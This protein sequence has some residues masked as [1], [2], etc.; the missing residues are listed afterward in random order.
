MSSYS[1][2]ESGSS[3]GYDDE[4][5][6][7]T[8]ESGSEPV[9][10][11]AA[12]GCDMEKVD[13]PSVEET[14]TVGVALSGGGIRSASFCLGGLQ[15][16]ARA[17]VLQQA[18]YLSSVSGGGYTASAM[19]AMAKVEGKAFD[20]GAVE[21]V[22]K[23]HRKMVSRS[24]WLTPWATEPEN[25]G[26]SAGWRF[27]VLIK[28]AML[29]LTCVV[30]LFTN[31]VWGIALAAP[32]T[33]IIDEFVGAKLRASS[34]STSFFN[35]LLDLEVPLAFSIC[36]GC[37]V[38]TIVTW[39][40]R[41]SLSEKPQSRT[42]DIL[43]TGTE[44]TTRL[45]ALLSMAVILL[46][47][48]LTILWHD[49]FNS[50]LQRTAWTLLVVFILISVT[51]AQGTLRRV[52]LAVGGAIVMAAALFGTA[53]IAK[54]CIEDANDQ[55]TFA[56]VGD[57]SVWRKAY[58]LGSFALLAVFPFFY[59]PV[60]SLLPH[61]YEKLLRRAFFEDPQLNMGHV[62][63]LESELGWPIWLVGTTQTDF[64]AH[65]GERYAAS[66][67]L[68]SSAKSGSART[69][70]RKT[71][72]TL[73]ASRAVSISGAVISF[74]MGSKDVSLSP[75]RFLF[76]SLNLGLGWYF[77]FSD[78]AEL[79]ALV[80]NGTVAVLGA[81]LFLTLL[82][83][84]LVWIAVGSV[85]LLYIA[86]FFPF[87]ERS[88]LFSA[89]P[90]FRTVRVMLGLEFYVQPP[91]YMYLSDGGH[92]E[93]LGLLPLFQRKVT[94]IY[95]FDGGADPTVGCT[96]LLRAMELAHTS[97]DGFYVSIVPSEAGTDVTSA[98]AQLGFTDS[99][100]VAVDFDLTYRENH[101]HKELAKGK[102]TYIKKIDA[103]K[104]RD[105]AFTNYF[106][107]LETGR[108]AGAHWAD[109]SFDDEAISDPHSCATTC[110]PWSTSG[111]F[112]WYYPL[113]AWCGSKYPAGAY[114]NFPHH[115]TLQTQNF[116]SK[117][118][119]AYV[120]LG[121][122]NAYTALGGRSSSSSSSSSSGSSEANS[123]SSS[124]SSSL[125]AASYEASRS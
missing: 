103:S 99:D 63:E 97:L 58:M 21:I 42:R 57:F 1:E 47:T 6:C 106:A 45:G 82:N 112:M 124:P 24:Q 61:T 18:K 25:D 71:P 38:I 60:T 118:F 9:V 122:D 26:I 70:F 39:L 17:G 84:Q 59:Y 51:P 67:F 109:A 116:P 90:M 107:S 36:G 69:G 19:Y 72:S 49:E 56:N 89:A 121:R 32:V 4:Y 85:I 33:I 91:P 75:F 31:I 66:D 62:A 53:A 48:F 120:R 23:V 12:G 22:D 110:C 101:T 78:H 64:H 40:V 123:S 46:V 83:F 102:L 2:S 108:A 29:Y 50:E 54:W 16:L 41:Q 7:V 14:E 105:A 87:H 125:Y 94:R 68:I 111:A 96:S 44:L 74:V 98:I 5:T 20:E 80:A 114:N 76:G 92:F 93:N 117:L 11:A 10:A 79:L 13:P 30:T 115:S 43:V 28:Y 119:E 8:E 37:I 34:S 88:Q 81:L 73:K 86:S 113:K 55:E 104:S 100:A 52:F 15:E 95:S 77:A 35:D 3:Y 65:I 27:G